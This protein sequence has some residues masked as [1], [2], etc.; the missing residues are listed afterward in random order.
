VLEVPAD[1]FLKGGVRVVDVDDARG[2]L[3]G[4]V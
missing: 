1:Q 2:P 3:D 4:Y